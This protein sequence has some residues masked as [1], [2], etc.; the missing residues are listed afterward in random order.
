MWLQRDQ[1]TN[2]QIPVD[3]MTLILK[4][5]EARMSNHAYSKAAK[6][7]RGVLPCAP[8]LSV[9]DL[10]Y[11]Y[12]DRNKSSARS[13]YLVVSLEGEWCNI[14]K[15][16]GSQLRK[17]SYRVRQTDCYLVPPS[18][19]YSAIAGDISSD[20]DTHVPQ[21]SRGDTTQQLPPPPDIPMAISEPPVAAP[22]DDHDS[23]ENTAIELPDVTTNQ[24]SPP[25]R[26]STRQR[27]LPQKFED[28]V[29]D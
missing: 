19:T 18:T 8:N 2:T 27:R 6:S 10:V 25:L 4:Q 1:F 29:L 24:S 20:E 12:D 17:T 22:V 3:D 5:H 11:L 9:G 14:R 13:R 15:F 16:V 26:R 28:F 7:P 21:S 23:C